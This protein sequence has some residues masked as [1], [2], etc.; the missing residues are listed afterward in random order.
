MRFFTSVLSVTMVTVTLS[1]TS[2]SLT[3]VR[4]CH[5][6]EPCGGLLLILMVWPCVTHVP[7][8][9]HVCHGSKNPGFPCSP[10]IYRD[11]YVHLRKF[12]ID[13]LRSNTCHLSREI[14]RHAKPTSNSWILK[15]IA[16]KSSSR[17]ITLNILHQALIHINDP[18]A[19]S[20][21]MSRWASIFRT[22]F[23]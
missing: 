9:Q 13:F 11:I 7:T 5:A 3:I 22:C 18:S 17:P 1:R 16:G 4:T 15:M 8:F 21:H 12:F 2:C 20:E 23:L 10:S 6:R 19:L 14:G